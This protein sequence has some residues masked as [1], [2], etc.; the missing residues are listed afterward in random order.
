MSRAVSLPQYRL[1]QPARDVRLANH[2]IESVRVKKMIQQE[3]ASRSD[4]DQ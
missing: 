4:E 3:H 1:T 2:G